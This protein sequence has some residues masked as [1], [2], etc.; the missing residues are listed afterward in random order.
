M[1]PLGY[2][3]KNLYYLF[4]KYIQIIFFNGPQSSEHQCTPETSEF[5]NFGIVDLNTKKKM[6]NARYR[7]LSSEGIQTNMVVVC[8]NCCLPKVHLSSDHVSLTFC[9]NLIIKDIK[10]FKEEFLF[11]LKLQSCCRLVL[12]DIPGPS[13]PVCCCISDWWANQ[14]SGGSH[15]SCWNRYSNHLHM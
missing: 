6:A 1:N 12:L 15:H 3:N 14:R 11:F 4:K 9:S 13:A 2:D 7:E 10:W 8:L 5:W